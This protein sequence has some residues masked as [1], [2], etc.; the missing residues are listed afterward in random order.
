MKTKLDFHR[1]TLSQE[2]VL[3]ALAQFKFLTTGQLLSLGAM[4]ERTNLNKNISELRKFSSPLVGSI[5]F[6]VH[7]GK[8]KLESV[9]YLTS[10]GAALL[11]EVYGEDYPIR[12]PKGNHGLFQQ[13]YFHRV[14]TVTVHIAL[15]QWVQRNDAE[16]LFFCTYFDKL[17]TGKEKGYRAESA[18]RISERQYLIADALFMLQTPGSPQLYALEMYNGNDTQRVHHSLTAHLTA[19]NNGQPSLQFGMD[20]ASRVLCVFEFEVYKVQL[21]KRLSE[22]EG[23]TGAKEFFLFKSLE[24]LKNEEFFEWQLFDGTKTGLF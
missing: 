17:S 10:H 13:D 21:M 12:F 5:S 15:W 20:Y 23:F 11:W 6:G 7:P 2:K 8:G 16:I 4:S 9:H 24:E 3:T 19:L 1:I 22:D 14:N 18:I